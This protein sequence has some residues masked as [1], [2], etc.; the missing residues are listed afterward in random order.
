MTF[1]NA[2]LL[3][4]ALAVAVP[5]YLHLTGRRQPKRVVFGSLFLLQR[6]LQTTRS[7]VRLRRW[8]L[9]LIRV[10][11]VLAIAAT[12]AGPAVAAAAIERL[13]LAAAVGVGGA[14]LLVAATG[15]W[16]WRRGNDRVWVRPAAMGLAVAGGLGILGAVVGSTVSV[17]GGPA[18]SIGGGPIALT[19]VVDNGPTTM[20]RIGG[21][22]GDQ[23]VGERSVLDW[24][25]EQSETLLGRLRAG[26][27][28]VVLDRGGGGQATAGAMVGLG[29]DASVA[30]SRVRGLS[31][32]E[33][34][35]PIERL[36]GLAAAGPGDREGVQRE[37]GQ[38]E[39]KP[40][41]ALEMPRRVVVVTDGAAA[42]FDGQGDAFEVDDGRTPI[43]VIAPEVEGDW[44]LELSLPRVTPVRPPAQTPLS[45]AVGVTRRWTGASPPGE[46][47][48]GRSE[49]E[50]SVE[51][52]LYDDDPSLPVLR[53]GE[54][55]LPDLRPVDRRLIAVPGGDGGSAEVVLRVDGLPVGTHH[56]VVRL[57]RPDAFVADNERYV[58]VEVQPGAA[59]LLVAEEADAGFVIEQSLAGVCGEITTVAAIDLPLVNLSMFAAAVLVDPA[60][61]TLQFEGWSAFVDGGG[62][63]MVIL[64]PGL[65]GSDNEVESKL[66]PGWLPAVGRVFRAPE[67]G[68]FIEPAADDPIVEAVDGDTPWFEFPVRQYFRVS[69]REN[70][71]RYTMRTLLRYAGA[72]H[73]A[74]AAMTDQRR[75][76]VSLVWTTP[77]PALT[78]PADAWNDLFGPDPWPIWLSLR[79]GL[80][81]LIAGDRMEP[82]LLVGESMRLTASALLPEGDRDEKE[83][84]AVAPEARVQW[85]VPGAEV[86]VPVDV[87]AG[88]EVVFGP[89]RRRGVHWVR[90]G[91][92]PTGFSVNLPSLRLR[93][94]GEATLKARVGAV[95]GRPVVVASSAGEVVLEGEGGRRPMPIG[96][97]LLV[98]AVLAVVAEQWLGGRR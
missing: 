17:A 78:P 18:V 61:S 90:G 87:V 64:G 38:R 30:A 13:S 12:L 95:A 50:L 75:G 69:P 72:G 62:G 43:Q 96:G 91:R 67:G 54:L 37:G 57:S 84:Q 94:V 16:L 6:T 79:K 36:V 92:R 63:I 40:A 45:V 56:G 1:L 55:V 68:T 60:V 33:D 52:L 10:V 44:Q 70:S 15:L 74:L 27:R 81:R 85:L 21:G 97:G 93:P 31:V 3:F 14:V 88:R 19:L 76:L 49:G 28:V 82:R 8:W 39:G 23:E 34:A 66:L 59:V 42:S 65:G 29:V 11:A 51:L 20:R 58:S 35:V 77:L 26:S 73:P 83:R 71:G 41:G 89:A 7:R 48:V 47:A 53:D 9:L 22:G 80:E 24:I 5:V 25:K 32:V 86:A 98:L 2:S 46:D 4:G